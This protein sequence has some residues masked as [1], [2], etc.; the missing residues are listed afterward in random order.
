MMEQRYAEITRINTEVGD[1]DL[2]EV[3]ESIAAA[4]LSQVDLAEH[5]ETIEKLQATFAKSKWANLVP[6]AIEIEIQLA[7]ENNI[8][9]CKLD[10]V[11]PGEASAE[12]GLPTFE[13]VDWKTGVAPTSEADVY[14]RSLQLALYRLAFATLKNVPLENVSACLYYVTD[15][16]TV[17][18]AHML[19]REEILDLWDKVLS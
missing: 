12:N 4:Q 1:I 13:V 9:I 2:V 7:V 3:G 6:E 5:Q 15:D 16:K 19:N 10:A 14:E 17:V 11:F 18:P 8:F